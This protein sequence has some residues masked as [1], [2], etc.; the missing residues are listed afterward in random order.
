M[1]Q[2]IKK[3]YPMETSRKIDGELFNAARIVFGALALCVP[4]SGC[5]DSAPP[6]QVCHVGND[7]T[8]VVEVSG[9]AEL[10]AHLDHGD[11]FGTGLGQDCSG[12][13]SFQVDQAIEASMADLPGPNGTAPRPIGVLVDEQGRRD[14]Y[15]VHEVEAQFESEEEL[16]RFLVVYDAAV[17]RDDTALVMDND[18]EITGVPHGLDGWHLIRI[19]ADASVLSDLPRLAAESGMEGAFHASSEEALRTFAAFKREKTW[20][21]ELNLVA[22]ETGLLEH[23]LDD[24]GSNYYDVSEEWWMTEDDDPALPGDQGIS[25]GVAAAFEYLRSTGLPPRNGSWEPARVAIIDRGFDL[26]Q[27]TGLGNA[28]YNNDPTRAPLQLDIVDGD[29]RPGGMSAGRAPWHGQASFGVC[30]AY[31]RN[32]F[33]GAG[34][35]GEHVRPILIRASTTAD[36]ASAVRSAALMDA[37]VITISLGLTC[38]QACESQSRLQKEI[39]HASNDLGTVVL[40]SAG[41]GP[42]NG[43]QDYNLDGDNKIPCTLDAVLCV[44]AIDQNGDNVWNW[45]EDVDIWAPTNIRSTVTPVT[46]GNVGRE[47]VWTAGG[48]SA[49]CPFAAGIV[50]L[51]K[52]ANPNLK[53]HEV[54]TILQ[55]T[56][57]QSPGDA[58]RVLNGYVDALRAVQ[59]V[60]SNPAPSVQLAFLSTSRTY[61]PM[62]QRELSAFVSDEPS[63]RGFVGTVEFYSDMDGLLC[64]AEGE[65]GFLSCVGV[66]RTEG[67]HLI[68]AIATDEFG[69]SSTS[70]PVQITVANGAPHVVLAN[71][72]DGSSHYADQQPSFRATVFDTDG[73]QFEAFCPGPNGGACTEWHSDIDGLLSPSSGSED[74]LNFTS[75]LSRGTHTITV[76]ARDAFGASTSESVTVVVEPGRGVPTARILND[77][78]DF[79]WTES[80]V[81]RGTATD[82]EDG[83]PPA[84]S[85]QWFSTI[86]G[87]LGAGDALPVKLSGPRCEGW[88]EHIITLFVTDSDG[89]TSTDA[90]RVEFHHAC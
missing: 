13:V 23:P 36:I 59:A 39:L 46:E 30:C 50:G 69:A 82:P 20:P 58:A 12:G 48:T 41:N 29:D 84:S 24:S 6:L 74:A 87:F 83:P 78:D 88:L 35:G 51:L 61:S 18:G 22:E 14:E 19:G 76:T 44:G 40:A 26:D 42:D 8:E 4:L 43:T 25:V 31:P 62:R 86:D 90:V 73:E 60:R 16:E 77:L 85:F 52:T 53:W 81:L 2:R 34:T 33:G 68:T 89:N 32:G 67:E 72:F 9:E 70:E 80:I 63:P 54:Q 64:V 21:V 45:G 7:G 79:T 47:A 15:I 57:N 65:A 71:P 55:D 17:L 27:T 10:Q 38:S 28:D 11:L 3:D 1:N 5:Q 66:L 56:A 49:A 37:D 75:S